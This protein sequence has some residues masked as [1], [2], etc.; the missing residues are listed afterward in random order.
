VADR[1]LGVWLSEGR[2]SKVEISRQGETYA[3]R[4]VW[5]AQ[6]EQD[7]APVRDGKNMN[8]ALRNRPIMGLEILSG[9][10]RDAKGRWRGGEIYS[11]RQGKSYPAELAL[12]DDDRLEIT[13]RAGI[14][15]KQ[16]VWT[17]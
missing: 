7:G 3:G 1:I 14:L 13:V 17:R 10:V 4:V 15:S 8:P 16:V 2:D 12:A 6:P 5:L 11:P 9:F